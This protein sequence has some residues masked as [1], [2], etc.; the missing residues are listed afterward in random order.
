MNYYK[1][2]NV[3]ELENVDKPIDSVTSQVT[4]DDYELYSV[5]NSIHIKFHN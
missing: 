1:P 4:G 3:Y 5:D 2:E